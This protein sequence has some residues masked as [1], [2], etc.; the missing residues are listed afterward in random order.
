MA[1]CKISQD[2]RE[3]YTKMAQNDFELAK[4]V[5]AKIPARDNLGNIIAEAQKEDAAKNSK[6]EE[7]KINAKV[8]EVVGKD[9][10]F[11]TL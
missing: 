6:S 7:E 11:R 4:N 5:L 3:V 9:F 2:E 1:D 8:D 10:Q